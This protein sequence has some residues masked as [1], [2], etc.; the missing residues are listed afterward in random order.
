MQCRVRFL[1]SHFIPL[2]IHAYKNERQLQDILQGEH[3]E[4]C[5]GHDKVCFFFIGGDPL[6]I[7]MTCFSIFFDIF[8]VYISFKGYKLQEGYENQKL[9]YNLL[10]KNGDDFSEEEE[11]DGKTNNN[12]LIVNNDGAKKKRKSTKKTINLGISI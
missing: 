6:S 3:S 9:S 5:D 1:F 2:Y 11:D 4:V 8:D 12:I 7:V 10:E